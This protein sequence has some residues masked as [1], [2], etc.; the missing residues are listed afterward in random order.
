MWEIFYIWGFGLGSKGEKKLFWTK[1]GIE[2]SGDTI[3]GK[4]MGTALS[5]AKSS[6]QTSASES[7]LCRLLRMR[8]HS[9][10]NHFRNKILKSLNAKL[11]NVTRIKK[12]F[13][14]QPSDSV[15]IE[16]LSSKRKP[17]IHSEDQSHIY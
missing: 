15:S 11:P 7:E 13:Q 5:A 12:Q 9:T 16:R 10:C 6:V 8:S 17:R 14:N 4:N 1:A 2:L 3:Q